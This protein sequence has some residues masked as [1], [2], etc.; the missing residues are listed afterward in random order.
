MN[1]LSAGD[2]R[3][4]KALAVSSDARV[5]MA[6]ISSADP[7]GRLRHFGGILLEEL[8]S[9]STS[10]TKRKSSLQSGMHQTPTSG[11]TA[12]LSRQGRVARTS[13]SSDRGSVY[14]PE[15]ACL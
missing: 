11:V 13:G 3:L 14:A 12:R 6:R 15:A 10:K 1:N 8:S 7:W 2:R 5:R 4:W 9:Q